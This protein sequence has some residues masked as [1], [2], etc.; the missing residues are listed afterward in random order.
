M[1]I[2]INDNRWLHD[3][4]FEFSKAF[5]FLKIE[6]FKK[7]HS[8]NNNIR[9]H[10]H[11]V[12]VKDKKVG[13]LRMSHDGGQLKI[14]STMTVE[15]LQSFFVKNFSLPVRVFRKAGKLWLETN[16]TSKWTL[17]QQNEHGKETCKAKEDRKELFW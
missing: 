12:E 11:L 15:Q 2:E 14:T 1:T 10:H 3:L 7:R 6:F 5:P 4:Q 13:D 16:L 8:E 17:H 9:T